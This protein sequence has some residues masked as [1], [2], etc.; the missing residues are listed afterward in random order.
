MLFSVGLSACG[1]DWEYSTPGLAEA[2]WANGFAELGCS[3][4]VD[5]ADAALASTT[6]FQN[7]SGWGN[8][9]TE[10]G[11]DQMGRQNYI[12]QTAGNYLED[13]IEQGNVVREGD[14]Y[15]FLAGPCAE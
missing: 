4:P 1:S 6:A 7:Y 14:L 3:T 13:A 15:R 5:G 2:A 10:H 11:I 9:V 12:K 8:W